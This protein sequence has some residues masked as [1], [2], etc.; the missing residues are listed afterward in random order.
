M[1]QWISVD[2][3]LPGTEHDV[4]CYC[5]DKVTVVA[6]LSHGLSFVYSTTGRSAG[7]V[8]HWMPLP[9]APK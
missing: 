6:R 2:E 3:R 7:C 1:T 9:E 4:L 5:D 8:T